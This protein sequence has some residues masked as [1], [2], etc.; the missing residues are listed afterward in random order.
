[1][2][3]KTAPVV[4]MAILALAPMAH[5]QLKW[6]PKQSQDKPIVAGRESGHNMYMCRVT[7]VRGGQ[8]HLLP[9]K[10]WPGYNKCNVGAFETEMRFDNFEKLVGNQYKWVASKNVGWPANAVIG[11]HAGDGRSLVACSAFHNNGVH[12]GY[13]NSDTN[14][15]FGYDGKEQAEDQYFVLVTENTSVPHEKDAHPSQESHSIFD[16]LGLGL[17]AAFCAATGGTCIC[18]FLNTGPGHEHPCLNAAP[19]ERRSQPK[20]QRLLESRRVSVLIGSPSY[21]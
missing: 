17:V 7:L 13:M 4:A 12:P 8:T 14:C 3:T 1:M 10:T 21:F 5:A 2:V 9:G 19:I 18:G 16:W 6:V 20:D 15:N 11:D